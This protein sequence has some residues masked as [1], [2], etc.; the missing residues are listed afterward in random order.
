M[1]AHKTLLFLVMINDLTTT[2]PCISTLMIVLSLKSCLPR[3][4]FQLC[5]PRW[6]KSSSGQSRTIC[7]LT[8]RRQRNLLYRSRIIRYPSS[9]L[10]WIVN[11]WNLSSRQSSWVFILALISSGIRILN[12]YVPRRARGCMRYEYSREAVYPQQTCG[13]STAAS[14]DPSLSML[15][16]HGIHHSC[17]NSEIKLNRFNG[18]QPRSFYQVC[19]TASVL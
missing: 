13:L 19:P 18:E 9:H 14:L 17:R 4:W 10:W 5:K 6:I 15:A 3:A 11:R 16:R 8:S 7:A 12:M 2:L 1:S